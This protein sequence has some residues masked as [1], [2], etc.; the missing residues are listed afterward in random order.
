[1]SLKGLFSVKDMTKGAP[2]KRIAEFA[3]PMLIGNIAQQMYN[4]ADSVI[5]G[6]YVGD[7]ALAAVGS[8]SPILNLLLAVFVGLATGASITISQS[9]G[10]KDRESLSIYIGNCITLAGIATLVI[11]VI[12]PLVTM[13]MLRLLNTPSSI[14][15]WCASY[16]NIYFIGIAGF[17]FYNMFS[18]ILRGM[19]DSLSALAFLLVAAALN[20]GLDLLFVAKFNMGVAGVSLATVIAQGISAAL[21]LIKLMGMRDVFDLNLES[22]KLK[23]AYSQKVI[24]IGIPSGVT[25]GIMSISMLV[26][27]SLT[28]SMGELVIACSVLIM[29]VDGFAMMP[30]MSFGNAMSVYTGQNVGAGKLDRVSSGVKQGSTMAL[31]F[32]GII[33]V[34][35]LFFGHYL[36]GIFT[37]TTGL[38][39]L[40]VRMMR[41]LAAGY[42]CVSISQ[43]LGGTMRGAGDTVT[44]MW[45][46]IISTICLRIPV[47]YGLAALTRSEQY[48]NGRPE[49]LYVSLLVSWAM[50]AVI[51]FIAFKIGKWRNKVKETCDAGSYAPD[52]GMYA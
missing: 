19:G 21:C 2:W 23:R 11:M 42:L 39:N 7:N 24:K 25:Q 34:V 20:V 46:S 17:F 45:I 3:V 43:C 31:A 44:P 32:S 41:I 18:G 5:V 38:I 40:A 29:R 48:P 4:T 26:V 15:D 50:G 22:L 1:M 28:N 37:K 13:P 6:Q 49:A 12:G 35:L 16:L 10:A 52:E 8:A 36:F 9:F 27:Q 33:T 47:A 51:S 30:N 14:I